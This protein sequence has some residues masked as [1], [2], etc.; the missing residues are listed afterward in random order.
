M[1]Q[2]VCTGI[3][4]DKLCTR[5][6]RCAQ[7]FALFPFRFSSRIEFGN[8]VLPMHIYI[9]IYVYIYIYIYALLGME[10]KCA[11]RWKG[12]SCMPVASLVAIVWQPKYKMPLPTGDQI[13]TPSRMPL[14]PCLDPLAPTPTAKKKGGKGNVITPRKPHNKTMGKK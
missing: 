9:Y 1:L 7:P 13:P 6:R 11:R 3:T 12:N 2:Q 10:E 8:W 14:Q 4:Q 5:V